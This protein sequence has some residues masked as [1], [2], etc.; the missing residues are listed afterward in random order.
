M[1]EP[2]CE[3]CGQEHP[4][5][6]GWRIRNTLEDYYHGDT[7]K[8][9]ASG[10]PG[11][12]FSSHEAVKEICD[13]LNDGQRDYEVE[14]VKIC[15]AHNFQGFSNMNMTVVGKHCKTCGFWEDGAI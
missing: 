3:V 7:T 14:E 2:A 9:I 8:G 4:R 12:Q 5:D 1:N 6:I 15:K 10:S 13:D 11:R